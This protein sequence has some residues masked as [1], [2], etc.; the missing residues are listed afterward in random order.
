[1]KINWKL[2]L[3]NKATIAALLACIIT[4]VYQVLSILGITPSIAESQVTE[5]VGL[6]LNILAA[7]GIL[8]DPTTKGLSDS[9]KA[10]GYTKPN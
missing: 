7:F 8:V 2:R 5:V 9:E 4:F 3:M 6:I 10:L 1:M